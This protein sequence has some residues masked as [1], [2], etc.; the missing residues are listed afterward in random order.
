VGQGMCLYAIAWH[1]LCHGTRRAIKEGQMN[2]VC[3]GPG[4][5][6]QG[7]PTH[8][9][10]KGKV[11]GMC[12]GCHVGGVQGVGTMGQRWEPQR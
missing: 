12:V 7:N 4:V 1:M 8:T 10:G 3:K 6:V 9:T 2:R 11:W 5:N